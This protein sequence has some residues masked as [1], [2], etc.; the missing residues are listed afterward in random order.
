MIGFTS[1]TGDYNNGGL[2]Q[3]TTDPLGVYA[4][5]ADLLINT[6]VPQGLYW[7][8]DGASPNR[9]ITFE[10]NTQHYNNG[11]DLYHFLMSFYESLPNIVTIDFLNMTGVG[12]ASTVGV[13]GS[14]RSTSSRLS[15]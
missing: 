12:F 2:P 14:S 7:Q 6:G 3:A 8:V 5:W 4:C 10:W 15:R 1:L 11:T 13:E 9:G